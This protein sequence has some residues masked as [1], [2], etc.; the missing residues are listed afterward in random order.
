[1]KQMTKPIRMAGAAAVAGVLTLGAVGWANSNGHGHHGHATG[2]H[3]HAHAASPIPDDATAATRAF[4]AA[5]DAM[6][7]AMSIEFTNDADVDFILGMIPHH[8]G[9]VE[10]ARIVLEH[11]TDPEVR[12]LATEIIDAQEAEIAWMRDWLARQDR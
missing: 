11:G 12:T 8:E 10:M 2:G 6:H 4:I 1:M 9:A 3:D 5:N 7:A